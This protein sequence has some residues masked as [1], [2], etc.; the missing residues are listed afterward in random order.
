MQISE[1][2]KTL[3]ELQDQHGDLSVRIDLVREG[4]LADPKAR[5]VEDIPICVDGCC[6]DDEIWL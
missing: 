4:V 2:I 5:F 3:Q 1:L 6:H